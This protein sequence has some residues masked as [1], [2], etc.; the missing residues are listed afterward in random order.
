MVS[1]EPHKIKT[2]RLVSFPSLEERKRNLGE[3][4]FNVFWLT[5]AQ[6]SFDMC[7]LGTS[8]VSQEQLAGQ[9]VGYESYAGSRNFEELERAVHAVLGHSYVC[10]THNVLGCVKLVV[11]TLV[12]PGSALPSNARTRMDQLSRLGVSYPDV[13]D[14]EEQVFTGNFDLTRLE[15][16]LAAGNVALVGLQ[17]FADG[18]HPISLA[19]LKAARALADR[20]GVKV[21]SDG[22][23]VIENAWS[24]Q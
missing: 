9:L 16:V 7:S 10:P 17:A 4:H 1:H 8:A 21:I 6:V 22:T 5:P 24:I 11:A 23:R 13:R 3:A 14:H 20:Y 19:N 18:Q 12:A 15:E 2:V